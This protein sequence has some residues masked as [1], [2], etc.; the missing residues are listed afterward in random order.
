MRSF[1]VVMS[2]VLASITGMAVPAQVYFLN[3]TQQGGATV[4]N[5]NRSASDPAR[6]KLSIQSSP[7]LPQIALE[8]VFQGADGNEH[9][10]GFADRKAEFAVTDV[11]VNAKVQ[12]VGK[13]GN[14]DVS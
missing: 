6:V 4:C 8:T 3:V 2:F 14:A 1:R 12:V 13:V 9:R 7:S 5:L 10:I 11:A